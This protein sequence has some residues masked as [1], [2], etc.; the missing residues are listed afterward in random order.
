VVCDGRDPDVQGLAAL[1]LLI[2]LMR[3][4]PLCHDDTIDNLPPNVDTVFP[5]WEAFRKSV[6]PFLRSIGRIDTLDKDDLGTGFLI[7]EDILVT[8]AHVDDQV[9]F[10]WRDRAHHNEPKLMPLS[11]DEF[12]SRFLLH[13]LPP[14]FVRIRHFGFLANRRRATL[15]PLCFQLLG[16]IPQPQIEP[17]ASATEPP[18]PLYRCPKC[19]GTMVIIQTLTAAQILLRSPPSSL[20]AA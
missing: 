13:L 3:P 4:A 1:E 5:A 14:G 19:G 11:L 8:N 10:R 16:P 9:T 18:S 20:P 2:K 6:K 12:L 7:S 17:T 15:L